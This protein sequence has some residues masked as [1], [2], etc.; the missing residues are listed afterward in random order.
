MSTFSFFN[1]FVR[2]VDRISTG[3]REGWRRRRKRLALVFTTRLSS[4]EVELGPL[5]R[6]IPLNVARV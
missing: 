5:R 2:L 3:Y 6:R 4:A 1:V